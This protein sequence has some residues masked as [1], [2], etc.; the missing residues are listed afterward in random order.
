[1][2]SIAQTLF[3]S[4]FSPVMALL[5]GA[6]LLALGALPRAA[7]A[8][9][10]AAV[11]IDQ[12]GSNTANQVLLGSERGAPRS[13]AVIAQGEL[14]PPENVEGGIQQDQPLIFDDTFLDR[15]QQGTPTP[16]VS[17]P[18]EAENN[19]A[20]QAR[21]F[22][23]APGG[24]PLYIGQGLD[25]GIAKNNTAIQLIS[26]GGGVEDPAP[27]QPIAIQQGIGEGSQAL[28][29]EAVITNGNVEDPA[30]GQPIA[31]QQGVGSGTAKNGEAFID[32]G[33][34]TANDPAPGWPVA[35]QQGV[36]ANSRAINT[37]A[38][39]TVRGGENMTLI[40]QGVGGSTAR[41][42]VATQTIR[43]TGHAALIEQSG[44]GGVATQ[45]IG[46]GTMPPPP[47]PPEGN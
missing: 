10:N 29:S 19:T 34:A 31:I 26:G 7:F 6:V 5:V 25:G 43:G 38:R 18:G 11:F 23:F 22:A 46:D 47:P 32:F 2:Q 45:Q 14:S 3:R 28:N 15:V 39:I 4:L 13:P 42:S 12:V 33:G 44:A 37:V 21:Q 20:V 24:V 35:I 17:G 27:G 8:Q 41:N 36:G 1:M 9:E 40:R 16:S 30:P